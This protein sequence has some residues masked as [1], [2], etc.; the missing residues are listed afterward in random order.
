MRIA[1]QASC[2]TTLTGWRVDAE[3][4]SIATPYRLAQLGKVARSVVA[5]AIA[6]LGVGRCKKAPV[7]LDLCASVFIC[8]QPKSP[9]IAADSGHG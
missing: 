3:S 7:D 8:G 6:D 2:T 5:K 4:I 1:P 9:R